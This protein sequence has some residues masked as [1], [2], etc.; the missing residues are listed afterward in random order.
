[1]EKSVAGMVASHEAAQHPPGPKAFDFIGFVLELALKFLLTLAALKLACKYW[2]ADVSWSGILTVAA[3]DGVVRGSMGLAGALLLGFPS[4][5]YAD[6][7]VGG[8]VMV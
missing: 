8:I 1:M 6:E 7:A 3:A 2:G 5:F 4:L